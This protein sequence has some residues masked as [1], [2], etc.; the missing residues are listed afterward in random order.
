MAV[1]YSTVSFLTLTNKTIT[2]NGAEGW[3]ALGLIVTAGSTD[4]TLTGNTSLTI[5]GQPSGSVVVVAG[6]GY[7]QGQGGNEIDG[8]TI[9]APSG[10]TAYIGVSKTID[11]DIATMLLNFF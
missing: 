11:T 10:C 5:G 9:A 2:I 4:L 1:T 3:K 8:L 6:G 7:S